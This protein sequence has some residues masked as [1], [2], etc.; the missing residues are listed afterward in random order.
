MADSE[1]ENKL[2]SK[3]K[4]CYFI[5][6]TKGTKAYMHW[7]LEKKSAFVSRDVI[8]DEEFMLQEN[9]KTEDKT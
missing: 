7:D 8:F 6:F 2:E 3:L 1:K 5:D 4:M 9:S